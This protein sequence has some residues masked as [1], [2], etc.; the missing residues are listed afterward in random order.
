M[1]KDNT[2]EIP[3][4][5]MALMFAANTA[6]YDLVK[7]LVEKGAKVNERDEVGRTP[8]QYA[9]QGRSTKIV[10]FLIE[11]GAD[12]EEADDKYNDTAL[13]HAVMNGDTDTLECLIKHGAN[14]NTTKANGVTPL[15]VC[16]VLDYD[17]NASLLLEHGADI[18]A[19]DNE[20]KDALFYAKQSRNDNIINIL[21]EEQ[22]K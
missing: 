6:N 16:A 7:S 21:N 8:L 18:N 12:I 5:S 19:K 13:M 15:M 20:D 11:N 17:K 3:E 1:V 9:A 10:E 4:M 14:V 22:S 2:K